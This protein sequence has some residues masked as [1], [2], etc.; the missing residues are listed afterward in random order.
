LLSLCS[1]A[2]TLLLAPGCNPYDPQLPQVPFLCGTDDPRCPEGFEPVN[3]SATRCECHEEGT[4]PTELPDAG[5]LDCNDDSSFEP[6]EDV[7]EA[8]PTAIGAS[9]S[10]IFNDM[11][12]C[13]GSDQ[14]VFRMMINTANTTIDVQLDFDPDYGVLAL[15]I[16]NPQ[17]AVVGSGTSVG[18]GQ[19]R[20]TAVASVPGTYYTRVKSATMETNNYDLRM[21]IIRP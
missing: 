16:L 13:P 15:E 18:E 8:T 1:I 4:G 5:P 20:A 14:D 21:E 7:L 3:V 10:T 12:I 2:G 9:T 19:L 6:N 17:S 11:A